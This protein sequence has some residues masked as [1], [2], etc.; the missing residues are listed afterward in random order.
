LDIE[1]RI[2]VRSKPSFSAKGGFGGQ[3]SKNEINSVYL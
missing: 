2:G 3:G 1:G